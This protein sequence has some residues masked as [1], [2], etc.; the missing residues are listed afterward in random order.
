MSDLSPDMFQ[1]HVT[2]AICFLNALFFFLNLTNSCSSF[3]VHRNVTSSLK[4]F[5]T[6]ILEYLSYAL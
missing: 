1:T 4:T 3:S 5:L 2:L 6:L